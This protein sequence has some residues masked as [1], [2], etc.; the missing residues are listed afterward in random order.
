MF[1]LCWY[2]I[3]RYVFDSNAAEIFFHGAEKMGEGGERA[4][5]SFPINTL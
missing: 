2:F 5:A 1:H 3:I 4:W